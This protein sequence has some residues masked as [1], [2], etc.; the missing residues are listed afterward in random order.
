MKILFESE[1]YGTI[2][3]Y[4]KSKDL[5]DD[6]REEFGDD[7]YN[8]TD[9]I[10]IFDFVRNAVLDKSAYMVDR[11]DVVALKVTDEINILEQVHTA[12]GFNGKFYDYTAQRFNEEFAD[13]IKDGKIPV[14]Q[15]IIRSDKQLRDN[16]SSVKGYAL[17]GY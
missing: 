16:I 15:K 2:E 14:V 17:L 13:L 10:E 4:L 3:S 8:T 12:I 5:V 6:I 7:Y 9:D 1:S 11:E